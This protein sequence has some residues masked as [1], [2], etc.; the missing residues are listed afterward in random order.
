M[1]ETLQRWGNT[2]LTFPECFLPAG[3]DF[4]VIE[5]Q[6]KH[7][8]FNG[9]IILRHIHNIRSQTMNNHSGPV[10]LGRVFFSSY[11]WHKSLDVIDAGVICYSFKDF[12]LTIISNFQSSLLIEECCLKNVWCMWHSVFITFRVVIPWSKVIWR[13]TYQ[14]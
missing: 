14:T 11:L 12:Q 3:L 2:Q 9:T 5:N 13:R 4:I 6:C 7:T 8:I 1:S 10:P